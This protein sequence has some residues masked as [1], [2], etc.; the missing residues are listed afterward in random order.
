[1]KPQLLAAFC[2]AAAFSTSSA[3][4]QTVQPISAAG[5]KKAIAAR[6]GRPVVVNVWAT[7]CGP[8]VA[9][10]PALA[11]LQK[12]YAK[13]GLALIFVSADE[14]STVQSSVKPFL[15]KHK[16]ASSYLIAGAAPRFA[17]AFDP[18]STEAF[19]LP[20]TYVYN[21]KGQRV[22]AFSGE[23]SYAQWQAIVQPLL[24]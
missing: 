11:R 23:R 5:L 18:K 1:M 10:M 22:K 13:R 4:A 20:R 6:K 12:T 21:R 7:W 14:A 24:K 9:E 19:A 2:A 15:R 17:E 8:C 3:Q 16:V